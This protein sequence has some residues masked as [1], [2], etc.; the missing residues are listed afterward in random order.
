MWSLSA[1]GVR[2]RGLDGRGGRASGPRRQILVDPPPLEDVLLRRLQEVRRLQR[3]AMYQHGVASLVVEILPD[4]QRRGLRVE[5]EG[6]ETLAGQVGV[7]S[8]Q[9]PVSGQH[10]RLLLI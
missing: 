7:V 1:V 10:R 3:V 5:L 8:E 2:G 4:G 9:G 6:V